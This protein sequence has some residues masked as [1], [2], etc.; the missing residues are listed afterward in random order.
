VLAG[1]DDR[2]ERSSCERTAGFWLGSGGD[3]GTG[4]GGETEGSFPSSKEAKGLVG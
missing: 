3:T 1:D 2:V 4:V